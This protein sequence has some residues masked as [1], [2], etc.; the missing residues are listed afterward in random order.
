MYKEVGVVVI[1]K[2]NA[3]PQ[4]EADSEALSL[5]GNN[6]KHSTRCSIHGG[7]FRFLALYLRKDHNCM[8]TLGL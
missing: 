2:E 3:R 1:E 8:R 6:G 7:A 5:E 4:L